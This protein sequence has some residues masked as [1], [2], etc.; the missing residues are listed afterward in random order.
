MGEQNL[1]QQKSHVLTPI[2]LEHAHD[3]AE[4]TQEAPL[5]EQLRLKG[6]AQVN[7]FLQSKRRRRLGLVANVGSAIWT[8]GRRRDEDDPE[9]VARA[10]RTA[11][12]VAAR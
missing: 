3:G 7:G 8:L 12:G 2:C 9:E 1:V 10:R 5:R 4:V 6:A 11:K